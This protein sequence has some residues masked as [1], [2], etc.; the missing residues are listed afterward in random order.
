[1]GYISSETRIYR[2][3]GIYIIRD[4]NIWNTYH[5]RPEYIEYISSETK[6]Y[7][8]YIIRDHNIWN[9]YHQR[10]E[11]IEYI[12]YT[13]HHRPEYMEYISSHTRINILSL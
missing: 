2:I 6:I 7:R 12:G 4:Q 9:I 10:P 8:I 5:Q 1:M 13:I 11:Y 3:Y